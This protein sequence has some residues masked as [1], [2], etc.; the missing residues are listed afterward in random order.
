M[1]V[2]QQGAINLTAL[3]VPDVYVQIIPPSNY[4]INGLPTNILGVVGTATWGPVNSPTII[5]GPSMGPYSQMFGP[6]MPRTYDM[7]TA[8]AAAILQGASNFRCVRVTDG[9]DI[10][11][12][13]TM[14]S[15][16]LTITSK[17]SGSLGNSQQFSIA[18]GSAANSWRATVSMPGVTPEVFDN[19]AVGLSGNA[20]W[21]AIASA[22]NT[23]VS[24][25][26]G[27]SQLAVATAGVG[28]AAPVVATST[29]SGGTDGASGVTTT[30]LLGQDAIP[31]TG[32]YCLRNTQTSVAMLADCSVSTTWATQIAFGLSEGIYMIMVGPAGDT[33]ANATATKASA[34]IDSYTAKLLFGDWIYWND[35]VN[36]MI[37]L[38]SPQ[39]FIA[40][41]LSNLSPQNS[42]LNKQLYGIVGTQKSMQNQV[43][44]GADLQALG[45]A[46][47]DIICNPVPGGSYFGARF[48]WNTSSNQMIHGDNYV[49]MTNYLA[50]TFN[51]G[52]GYYV[53]KTNT[54]AYGNQP[55][56]QQQAAATLTNFLTNLWTV[57][58]PMI[59]NSAGTIPFSVECDTG[60]NPQNMVALGY[61]TANV[62]VTYLSIVEKFIINLMGGQSVQITRANTQTAPS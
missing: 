17:Y 9:T 13:T 38:I 46:G 50:Y 60:N 8:V 34:G 23:G 40:G 14:Q 43:Y 55:G 28:T 32:M 41:L 21:V 47:I 52:M 53:G 33:I 61:L 10:A 27:P 36:N 3:I 37:R 15:N 6:V 45:Q 35:T 11:S 51:A 12:N 58:P 57:N 24:G 42:T 1:P 62:D 31:R 59:G 44:S 30:T 22:I 2:V 4:L 19:L 25:V 54:P 56:L 29:L 5:G 49:R 48:G 26:R 16:C 39:G 20:A 18:V 7:G